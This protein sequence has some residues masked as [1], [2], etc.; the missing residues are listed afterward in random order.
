MVGRQESNGHKLGDW[1]RQEM[2]DTVAEIVKSNAIPM[3]EGGQPF[4][5]DI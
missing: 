1:I 2:W 3:A 4:G 5:K